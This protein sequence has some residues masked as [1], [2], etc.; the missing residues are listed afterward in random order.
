MTYKGIQFGRLKSDFQPVICKKNICGFLGI[1]L[2]KRENGMLCCFRFQIYLDRPVLFLY[3]SCLNDIRWLLYLS[4]K[5]L[6]ASPIYSAFSLHGKG[7]FGPYHDS[8]SGVRTYENV[9]FIVFLL[10]ILRSGEPLGKCLSP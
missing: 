7:M 9:F 8:Y 10:K 3:L 2:W 4:L 6:A 1:F 5:L